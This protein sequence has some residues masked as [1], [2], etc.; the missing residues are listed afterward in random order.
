[1]L[2]DAFS[3][4]GQVLIIFVFAV[5]GLVAMTGL[6]IDG[7]NIYSDRRHAQNAADTASLAA[8]VVKINQEKDGALGCT[9]LTTPTTCGALV[10]N[11]ALN[12][13]RTNGYNS[14]IVH[15][16]V[17][18]HIPPTDGPYSNCADSTFNCQDYV[19]V[20]I[21]TNVDTW[22]AKVLGVRQL[23]NRVEAVALARYAAS[24]TPYEG[25]SLVELGRGRGACPSD[26]NVG[27]SGTVTLNG[28][29]IYVNSSNP[30]CAYKQTSC[31]TSLVLTGGASIQVFGGYDLNGCASPTILKAPSQMPWPPNPLIDGE[32]DE[33]KT[34]GTFSSVGG[35]TTY[36]PGNYYSYN[37]FPVN[38]ETSVLT[39][40]VYCI[41]RTLQNNRDLT[42]DGV[43]IYI[44]P[45]ANTSVNI[46]G[47]TV[48]LKAPTSGKYAGFLIYQDWVVGTSTTQSC[49]IQGNSGSQYTGLIFVPY[50]QMTI[51]GTSDPTGFSAQVIAFQLS[52]TGTNTLNFTYDANLLPLIPEQQKTGL[53]R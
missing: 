2:R 35:V 22:F 3:Q 8:A 53:T 37:S 29:G 47:G 19:Q 24:F 46:S 44:R 43:F 45:A 18:V 13:A 16:T 23:H 36:Q 38:N 12:M 30:A 6:A 25:M 10:Q 4:R 31:K 17:E 28:G 51:S 34:T 50:C 21:S 52:L 39:P 5:I 27:G 26:F 40:G 7:G 1:M 32:P 48:V 11:A 42:G 9:D 20:I 49:G 41:N 33:C 14:D 15:D